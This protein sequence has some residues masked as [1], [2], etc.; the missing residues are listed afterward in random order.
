VLVFRSLREAEKAFKHHT[1]IWYGNTV[2]LAQIMDIATP[3]EDLVK[4]KTK[5]KLKKKRGPTEARRGRPK[6]SPAKRAKGNKI[7]VSDNAN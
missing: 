6:T 7:A 3:G 5:S 4:T 1:N 2:Y